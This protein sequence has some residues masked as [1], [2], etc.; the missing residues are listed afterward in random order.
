MSENTAVVKIG[1]E[2]FSIVEIPSSNTAL[3][4][5]QKARLLGAVDLPTLVE[6]LGRVGRFIRI[7]YNGVAGFTDL[8]ISIREIGVDVTKLCDKSAVTVAKFKTASGS[9]IEDL[10]GTYQ[11]LIDGMEDIA[12]VTLA[13]VAEVAK[14]MAGAADQLQK[15]FSNEADKVEN[16][17]KATMKTKGSEEERKKELEETERKLEIDKQKAKQSR[18]DAEEDYKLF[19]EKYKKA[20]AKQESMEASA[21]NPFKALANGLVAPI[22]GGKKIFDTDADERR[23]QSAQEE[24]LQHLEEIKKQ[25]KMRSQALQDF[26]EFSK[27]IEH[28]QD[29]SE[30][31]QVA[32]DALHQAM[33]GL[34]NLSAVMMKAS[35]FWKMMQVHCET[36]AKEKMQR[37]IE[38]GMKR[39][40]EER[41]KVWT[42]PGFKKQAIEYYGRWVA[43]DDV[44]SV[45]MKKI[46]ETQKDLYSY[47]T[48]NPTTSQARKNVRELAATFAKELAAV[49]KDI[50]EKEFND[51]KLIKELQEEIEN[52]GN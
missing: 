46:Q 14:D 9:I 39:P 52:N 15:D 2:T 19:E 48:E 11:F 13:S 4:Q 23:A 42:A 32:V 36:M 6:D 31:A 1:N 5:E 26:A 8:Q 40:Q 3:V 28:C 37:M 10:Q 51:E 20:E 16:A 27:R 47:L 35:L 34:Q 29:D 18:E 45:Y 25:R 43:L 49:Q 38:A 22:T 21:S 41:I 44:C 50:S 30:L 12:L 24:K 7:A 17:L 33:G